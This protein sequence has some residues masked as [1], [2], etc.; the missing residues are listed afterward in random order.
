MAWAEGEAS[1]VR[2]VH[3]TRLAQPGAGPPPSKTHTSFRLLPAGFAVQWCCAFQIEN[4]WLFTS[5]VSS[6]GEQRW[7]Q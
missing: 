1:S 3:R 4:I 2:C 6:E 7:P 5:R